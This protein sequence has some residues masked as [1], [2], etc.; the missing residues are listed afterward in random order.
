MHTVAC[1]FS[2]LLSLGPMTALVV[3]IALCSVALDTVGLFMHSIGECV[4]FRALSLSL[5]LL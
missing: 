5:L 2:I 1:F 4:L 3:M